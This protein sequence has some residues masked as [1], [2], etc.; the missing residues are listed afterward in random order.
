M[1]NLQQSFINEAGDLLSTLEENVLLLEQQPD[2]K[3]IVDEIF[4]C[5]HTLK[6]SGAMFGFTD[7]SEFTHHLESLYEQ[8][9]SDKLN[10][11]KSILDLTLKSLDHINKLLVQNP[12]PSVLEASRQFLNQI[13][14][15]PDPQ[16]E[17]GS[18]VD[19]SATNDDGHILSTT[20]YI[21]FKPHAEILLNGT[22]P[23]YL[24][25]ELLELGEHMIHCNTESIPDFYELD[26]RELHLSWH[27]ILVTDA[28]EKTIK[29][30]FMFIEDESFIQIERLSPE[31]LLDSSELKEKL[32]QFIRQDNPDINA[33]RADPPRTETTDNQELLANENKKN[34]AGKNQ[35][36]LLQLLK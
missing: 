21:R 9:R 24:L 23:L 16:D 36:K 6:G 10:L 4:R 26:P 19:V 5:M 35:K 27:I 20:Y 31:N 28:D 15:G 33:L 3:A 13:Q 8:I 29:D 34:S 32:K 22:N 18:M 2:N 14:T 30:V 7:L 12:A 11:D 1:D 25:D 17:I